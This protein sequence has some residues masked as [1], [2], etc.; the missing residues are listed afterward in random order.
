MKPVQLS[1]P[2]VHDARG[3]KAW[4]LSIQLGCLWCMAG[5]RGAPLGHSGQAVFATTHEVHQRGGNGP[6]GLGSVQLRRII[7]CSPHGR[8]PVPV[9]QLA[10]LL[11]HHQTGHGGVA[12][13]TPPNNYHEYELLTEAEQCMCV[14]TV[15]ELAAGHS[16][17]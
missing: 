6:R 5:S 2:A 14:G 3:P 1:S 11:V 7:H 9:M 8:P 16:H 13:G 4:P 15:C 10:S 17:G 12:T